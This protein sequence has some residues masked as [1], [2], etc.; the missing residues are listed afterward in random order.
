MTIIEP[1]GAVPH[2]EDA[3]AL[4]L[5]SPR[6]V[7]YAENVI[8]LPAYVV[9]KAT[10][11]AAE[12]AGLKLAGIG[13]SVADDTLVALVPKGTRL[14]HLSGEDIS[15]PLGE[16]FAA[17]GIAYRRVSVYRA[18][19]VDILPAPVT[20]FLSSPHPKIVTFLSARAVSTFFELA[21]EPGEVTYV[22]ASER[23]AASVPSA[24]SPQNVMVSH[25]VE[26]SDFVDFVR[27]D[28]T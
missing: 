6:A 23:I 21:A 2:R 5:T 7:P 26:A 13:Q 15:R 17:Q 1:T 8:D 25:T 20:A 18:R 22:C 27:S 12:A 14:L 28:C 24:I 9:G 11:Q 4:L 10:A 19:P 16:N 3:R